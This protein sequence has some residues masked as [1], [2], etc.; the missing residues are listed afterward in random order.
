MNKIIPLPSSRLESSGELG[1][2][3]DS[4]AVRTDTVYVVYTSIGDTL[5]AVRVASG[6]AK[7]LGVPVTVIHFR[8]VPYALPVDAPCG[9]SPIQT[10][11]FSEGLRTVDCDVRVH[12]CLCRGERQAIP[13]AFTRQSL[14]VVGGRRR[15]WP[16]RSERMRRMLEAAGHF[17]VF[18]DNSGRSGTSSQVVPATPSAASVTKETSHA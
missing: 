3:H 17:V 13:L 2:E 15:W 18:I 11:A 9:F 6:F 1:V 7:P 8:A 16:T 4:A 14:I 10:E 5:A 12:V